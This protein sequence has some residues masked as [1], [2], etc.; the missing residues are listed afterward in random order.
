MN[1]LIIIIVL[2]SALL[3]P[4]HSNATIN[5]NSL[6]NDLVEVVLIDDE[7]YTARV[8]VSC[9]SVL[10]NANKG[11]SH[12]QY[13][14]GK[15]IIDLRCP[16][17]SSLSPILW[18]Q[19]SAMQGHLS[20]HKELENLHKLGYFVNPVNNKALNWAEQPKELQTESQEEVSPKTHTN[21]SHP[22]FVST[23]LV[24][25]SSIPISNQ[26]ASYT[27]LRKYLTEFGGLP[28]NNAIR[29]NE[30]INYFS[31]DSDSLNN[32]LPFSITTEVGPAPWNQK[33]KL[34]RI[35]LKAREVTEV[36]LL[37]SNFLFLINTSPS[38]SRDLETI[39]LAIT[40][41]L[42]KVSPD[43]AVTILT[44]GAYPMHLER[45]KSSRNIDK[46]IQSLSQIEVGGYH[47]NSGKVSISLAFFAA[48]NDYS[49]GG[50]NQIIVVNDG[51]LDMGFDSYEDL[52]E[53]VKKKHNEEGIRL[54]VLGV[55]QANIADTQLK[56][57][58]ESGGGNYR[59]V[60]NL[61]E[62]NKSITQETGGIDK[63]VVKD[64]RL[65]AIFNPKTVKSYRLIGFDGHTTA[66]ESNQPHVQSAKDLKSGYESTLLYELIPNASITTEH[67][68]LMMVKASYIDLS[69]AEREHEVSVVGNQ[70]NL[71]QSSEGFRLVGA[72]A[73]LGMLLKGYLKQSDVSFKVARKLLESGRSQHTVSERIELIKLLNIIEG[74]MR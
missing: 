43:D 15:L 73:S 59:Y 27:Y 1:N 6:P 20:A 42:Y 54:S 7:H 48:K 51:D 22:S 34:I 49:T 62:A 19:L 35:S 46:I 8:M 3:L 32:N 16:N 14:L 41:F 9:E 60:D 37:A 57:L 63:V 21:G 5:N 4:L 11:Y 29:V 50:L 31:Y 33:N 47:Q 24:P 56:Q 36:D 30:L 52:I 10:Y 38:M 70:V 65:Q 74:V 58:A 66:H 72:V 69:G 2:V 45:R 64:L 44:Y 40:N 12:F 53:F 61:F 18:L 25:V 67:D 68:E 13:A 39:K 17:A 26:T 23:K 55:G 71:E 28:P